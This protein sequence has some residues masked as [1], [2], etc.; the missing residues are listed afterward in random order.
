M[1]LELVKMVWGFFVHMEWVGASRFL[2]S[3][4]P[5]SSLLQV[6]SQMAFMDA[7]SMIPS[8]AFWVVK[9][10]TIFPISTICLA[11]TH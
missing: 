7:G 9:G 2:L 6:L 10:K 5:Y 4:T 8:I 11:P 1:Q 3:V